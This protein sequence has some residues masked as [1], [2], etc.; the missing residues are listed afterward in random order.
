MAILTTINKDQYGWWFSKPCQTFDAHEETA[1][2]LG[3]QQSV[4]LI[5]DTLRKA[6]QAGVPFDGIFSFSQG[7]SL[8]AYYCLLQHLGK[9]DVSFKYVDFWMCNDYH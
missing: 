4:E 3:F 8:A 7:A 5:T 6:E 1:C 2:D 9:L